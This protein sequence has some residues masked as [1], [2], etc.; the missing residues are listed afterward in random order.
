MAWSGGVARGSRRATQWHPRSTQSLQAYSEPHNGLEICGAPCGGAAPPA[1]GWYHAKAKRRAGRDRSK[2]PGA[3][4][5]AQGR[6]RGGG[7]IELLGAEWPLEV[8]RKNQQAA[9]LVSETKPRQ[10]G[11]CRDPSRGLVVGVR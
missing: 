3:L 6:L 10:A 5:Q 1:Q 7:A 2:I 8:D 9:N 4:R 11:E